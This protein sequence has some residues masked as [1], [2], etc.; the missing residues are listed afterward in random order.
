MADAKRPILSLT[1]LVKPEEDHPFDLAAYDLL[2][3]C[4]K[5]TVEHKVAVLGRVSLTAEFVLRLLKSADGLNE[6]DAAAFF[7]FDQR[8]MSFVLR[9]VEELGH[10]ERR[11]GRLWLT[12]AGLGLF[13]PGSDMPQIYEVEGRRDTV[14][15]DLVSLGP[16]E[17]RGLDEFE[18]WLP[19]LGLLDP[20]LASAAAS[21]VPAAFRRFYPEISS[22]RQ[23]V[24]GDKRF[25]YSIDAVLPGERFSSV[26]RVAV[27]ATGLRPNAGEADLPDWRDAADLED[28]RRVVEAAAAFVDGLNVDSRSDDAEAY[29]V[30]S[31]LAPEFLKEFLRRD[32]LAVERYYREAFTRAGEVRAD[33]QTV[34]LLGSLFTRSNLVRVLEALD[35]ALRSP[36]SSELVLWLTPTVRAWGAT[37]ALPELLRELR[38]RLRRVADVPGARRVV[39]MGL[40]TGP[41]E[42]HLTKAFDDVGVS[43]SLQVHRGLEILLVPNLMVAVTVHAPIGVGRGLPV[44]LGVLS[45]DPRVVARAQAFLADRAGAFL[46]GHR[47]SSLVEQALE[48]LSSETAPPTPEDLATS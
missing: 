13:Q 20:S 9:E 41:P 34:P 21:R 37:R 46:R 6:A 10:V 38:S 16:E 25:L 47:L 14:G 1:G 28:R 22:R 19:E 3:P 44:P 11:D 30:L 7:G 35:Y 5:F 24:P 29:E 26:V 18:R 36:M 33:R 8:D 23:R 43:Q 32:G 27:R 12:L 39:A 40:V 17:F 42:D 15:F 31:T 4:R 2:L 45:F 48:P